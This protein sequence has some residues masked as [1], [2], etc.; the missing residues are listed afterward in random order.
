MLNEETGPHSEGILEGLGQ[1]ALAPLN[2]LRTFGGQWASQRCGQTLQ[3]GAGPRSCKCNMNMLIQGSP[4]RG[5][6]LP[7]LAQPAGRTERTHRGRGGATGLLGGPNPRQTDRL[8][9]GDDVPSPAPAPRSPARSARGSLGLL[10]EGDEGVAEGGSAGSREGLP[11][12][13]GAK[14]FLPALS[15]CF[16]V[17]ETEPG[18]LS[19]F[20][21]VSVLGGRSAQ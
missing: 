11:S 4:G 18:R 8:P 7:G 15:P 13:L 17:E 10:T 5:G 3:S 19:P 2:C 20:W 6:R 9:P 21:K 16:T 14:S 1:W 12:N